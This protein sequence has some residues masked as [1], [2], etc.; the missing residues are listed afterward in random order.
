MTFD[1]SKIRDK[2]RAWPWLAL[3]LLTCVVVGIIAPWQ[4]G[5]LVWSLSKLALAAWLGYWLDRTIF[6]YARPHEA[7]SAQSASSAQM[8]RAIVLAA[9]MIA[10]ALSGCAARAETIP[11]AAEQY[12]ALLDKE[13]RM[14]FGL[15]APTAR[16]AAQV[17]Q[18]SRWRTDAE[19]YVGAKGLAQFM[20]ATASWINTAYPSQLGGG[21][22]PYSPGWSLRALAV[23]DRYLYDRTK[24]RTDCDRWWFALRGYNG[25]LGHVQAEARNATD[26]LDHTIVDAACGSARRSAKNCPENLGYPRKIMLRWEPMYLMAHWPGRLACRG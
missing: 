15:D 1:F 9:V 14:Q 6:P 4:L 10:L 24:G 25:G 23:Y 13:A 17:H 22:A 5:V 19:S 8:R 26:P 16:L 12:R 2:L 21:A 3:A 7:V 18:E 11:P 20:P